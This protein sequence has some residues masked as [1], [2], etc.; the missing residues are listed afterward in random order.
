MAGSTVRWVI[1]GTAVCIVLGSLIVGALVLDSRGP[2]SEEVT[3]GWDL[4]NDQAWLLPDLD[5]AVVVVPDRPHRREEVDAFLDEGRVLEMPDQH[6]ASKVKLDHTVELERIRSFEL[7]TNSW[8]LRGGPLREKKVGPRIAVLGD[9]VAMGHGVDDED[10]WPLL[11]EQILA[12][13][14]EGVEVLN[15]GCPATSLQ[16]MVTWCKNVGTQLDLDLLIWASRG[17]DNG[18]DPEGASISEPVPSGIYRQQVQACQRSLDV[19]V[20]VVLSPTS[21]FDLRG[22]DGADPQAL[23]LAERLHPIAVLDLNPGFRAEAS[24]KG[25]TLLVD[26]SRLEVVDQ[27]TGHVWLETTADGHELPLDVYALFEEEDQVSEALFFDGAHPNVEGNTLY[28]RLVADF[29][30]PML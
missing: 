2:R 19:P 28:A 3:G 17:V 10:A 21:A 29:V 14:V 6:G 22:R 5:R 13:E 18:M 16:L 23:E 8:R 15:A 4:L 12:V 25:E 20:V 11:M 26:G 9:S 30:A 24:G 1:R 27:E 7:T